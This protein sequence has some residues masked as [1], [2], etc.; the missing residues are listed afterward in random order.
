MPVKL[1]TS[2]A[3]DTW[4]A[5]MTAFTRV[6]G[7]LAAE[8]DEE[9]EISLDWY[10]IL[11]MLSQAEHGAMR[12]SDLADQVGLSRSATTRLIDRL[13]RDGLV[14]RRSC[15]TDR[16]GTFVGL[17]SKGEETFRRAGRVHLRGIDEHVG[18]HLTD[19]EL[20]HLAV[21]LTKLADAVDGEAL[22]LIEPRS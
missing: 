6:N 8:M 18:L 12:P 21:L 16:R 14:E 15:G 2:P 17:T 10:S 1:K 19:A 9:T 22:S 13:E 7:M 20:G 11:L 4:R 5:M 3:S